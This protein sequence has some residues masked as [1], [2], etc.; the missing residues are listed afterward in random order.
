MVTR[1]AVTHLLGRQRERDVLDRVL[2]AARDG[3]GGVLALHGEP[4]V[5][6]TALLDYAV[7]AASDFRVTRAVGVEGEMELPF[8]ALQQVCSPSLDLIDRLP[9]LQREALEVALGRSE[10]RAP[11][12]FLVGLAVLSL[13]SEAAEEQP[14]LCVV[15]DA[16]WL[17]RASARVLAFVARRLLAERIALVFATR[18]PIDSL[19]GLA[20]L[21]VEPLGHRDARALLDS[22]MTARLD[23]RVLERIVVET[24]GNPLALLELPRGLTPAQLAGGFGLASALP[25]SRGIE[26]SFT[27][28]LARL[29][30]DAR[31]LVLLAAAEP[32]GDP[33]LLWRAAK[34]LGIPEKAADTAELGGLLTLDGAVTFR[35]PI[36]RSA[37]Y[38]AAEPEE[39]RAVHRALA[40][41]TDPKIDPDRRAWHRA[42]AVSAPDEDVAAVLE[43]SAARAQA[44]GGFAAAAAF[45]ERATALTPDEARRS[46]RALAAAQAKVQAGALDDAAS[47]LATA[48]SS[49]LSELDQAAVALLRG[50]ISFLTTR[51][52]DATTQLLEAADRLRTLDPDLARETYLDALTAA[53]FAGPLAAPGTSSAEVA[54]AARAAPRAPTPRGLD[55][56]L[57]GLVALLTET[58]VA[59][60]PI[61]RE[62]HRTFGDE[63][64]QSEQLRWMWG[65]T[66]SAMHLWDDEGWE[67]LADRHLQLVRE[68][69]ALGDLPNAL[70]HRGQMHVFAGELT[71]AA[72]LYEAIQEATELTGTQLAP[73]HAVG[74]MAMRGRE[75]EARRFMDKAR[76]EVTQR[77]EGA[78]LEFIDWAEAVLCNG[79]GQYGEALAAARRVLEEAELVPVNWILPELI[80]AAVRTGDHELAV[81]TQRKLS[82]RTTASGTKWALGLSARSHALTVGDEGADDLYV[83]AIEHLTHTRVAVDLARAHLL[84]GEWLRRQNRRVDAREQ[85]RIAH[86]MFTAFGME[87]FAERARIELLATGEHART[88]TVETLGQLTPQEEQISRLVAQGNTNREIAAQ[89]FISPRTVEYHLH[90]AFRKLGVRSRT[91]LAGRMA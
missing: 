42:Q 54:R 3:Q 81:E 8:A 67:R 58:Y 47:L 84:Y 12:P 34:Q 56:L 60:A 35:H 66:V 30:L 79:L 62:T 73:Y 82:E 86:R 57:D 88:R 26:Q 72:S 64:S 71:A 20:E 14:I 4:G 10:G 59:A 50:Q 49:P 78:G 76:T 52:S 87:A 25:L 39:R 7:E 43:R 1:A 9:D 89:L 90:K 74:M 75:A 22:V 70:G 11:N 5:G 38:T 48:E 53:I 19:A 2:A 24:R 55:L 31:R 21:Q 36:A 45:L 23:E 85:L 51:G 40:A 41:A 16:Q 29:P 32:L 37:V 27:Q 33:A 83:E 68:T 77:G 15:D 69:G 65:G 61:L 18:T 46:G 13:L 17:D 63:M 6:K 44:R 91:E 28:R 80:E